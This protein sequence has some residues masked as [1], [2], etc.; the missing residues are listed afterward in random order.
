M[1]R[2]RPRATIRNYPAAK[3]LRR[4]NVARAAAVR[5]YEGLRVLRKAYVKGDRPYG[6]AGAG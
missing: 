6:P 2:P 1:P 5:D 3:P 4:G